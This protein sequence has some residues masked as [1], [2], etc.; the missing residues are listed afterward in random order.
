MSEPINNPDSPAFPVFPP[1]NHCGVEIGMRLRTYLAGQALAGL[2]ANGPYMEEMSKAASGNSIVVAQ[3][4][5]VQAVRCAEALIDR[6][7]QTTS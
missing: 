6:L 2:C 7:N 4:V 1:E 3:G 5:A